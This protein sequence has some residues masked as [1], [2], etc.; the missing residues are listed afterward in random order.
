MGRCLWLDIFKREY[1][2]I[3]IDQ[4]RL[5]FFSA[6]FAKQAIIHGDSSWQRVDS[7]EIRVE[8]FHFISFV[9]GIVCQ[10][11]AHDERLKSVCIPQFRG[12]VLRGVRT[13][14]TANAHAVK[15]SV[16]ASKPE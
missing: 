16:G 15:M 10:V 12:K 11:K 9:A 2:L 4:F 13:W 14:N 3:V 1:F 7:Q 8:S 6:N 5:Y